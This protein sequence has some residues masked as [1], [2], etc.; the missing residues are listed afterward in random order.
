[1]MKDDKA[2]QLG[3]RH[4]KNVSFA[5]MCFLSMHKGFRGELSS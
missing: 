5:M 4:S 2:K 3:A 1:M